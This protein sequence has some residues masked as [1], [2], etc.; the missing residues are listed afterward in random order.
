MAE[1]CL[2]TVL[3]E[4]NRWGSKV[5]CV[6]PSAWVPRVRQAGFDGYELW[7]N[8][9]L[10][11]PGELDAILA[12]GFPVPI[13]N[14][15]VNFKDS[16]PEHY[17]AVA[18]C[19]RR[20][21][22]RAVKYNFAASGNIEQSRVALL[23]FAALLPDTCELLCECHANTILEDQPTAAA[24]LATLPERFGVILHAIDT[25]ETVA[26]LFDL[27]GG[28]VR[29]LHLQTMQPLQAECFEACLAL[30]RKRGFAGGISLEFTRT[31]QYPLE[32]DLEQAFA[33]ATQ[34]LAIIRKYLG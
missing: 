29:H 14:T 12:T 20:L 10:C 22:C 28:R 26:S 9:V 11:Q 16:P 6:C 2:S 30:I 32:E 8:H 21:G 13:F 31:S 24:F 3:L 18:D 5:C 1:V 19:V 34:D 15:Y 23:D 17:Q 27:F 7:E 25:P 33:A 4:K